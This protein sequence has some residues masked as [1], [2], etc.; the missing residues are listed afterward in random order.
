MNAI[1]PI[2]ATVARLTYRS[3]LGRRRALLLIALPIVLLLLAVTFRIFLGPDSGAAVTLLGSF[4]LGFLVPLLGLIAGTGSIGPEIDDGSIIYLLAKPLSRYTI[5]VS[6]LVTGVTVVTLFAAVPTVVAGFIMTGGTDR[7][8]VGYGLGA[9]IG[10]IAYSTLFLLLA[11][12]SRNAVVIGLLYALVWEAV[13]G[14]YVPGA[15]TLSI[16]QWSLAV[17]E[18]VIG[19]AATP[20]GIDAAVGLPVAVG[21]LLVVIVGGTAYAGFRLRSIRLTSEE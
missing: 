9:L 2:N 8:A 13:V 12:V 21:L 4:A 6:K 16:Q 17:T 15:Q 7:I 18:K 1:N 19:S 14:G 11:V 3:L 20:L 10:G 5:I